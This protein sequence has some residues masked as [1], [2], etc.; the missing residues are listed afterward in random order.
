M[1]RQLDKKAGLRMGLSSFEALDRWHI[2]DRSSSIGR[3]YDMMIASYIDYSN[4]ISSGQDGGM[5]SVSEI[6]H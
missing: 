2:H 5:F 6:D 4:R 3:I 1:E